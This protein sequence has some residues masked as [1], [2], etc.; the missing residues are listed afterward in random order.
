MAF[1]ISLKFF[2]CLDEEPKGQSQCMSSHYCG[3]IPYMFS[4]FHSVYFVYAVWFLNFLNVI[5]NLQYMFDLNQ[6]V[7]MT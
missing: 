3:Y 5:L 4:S 2:H 6:Y 7:V 1:E